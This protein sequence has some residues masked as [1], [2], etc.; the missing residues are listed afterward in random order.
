MLSFFLK[1][2][3][4]EQRL[5]LACREDA[6]IDYSVEELISELKDNSWKVMHIF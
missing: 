5:S 4:F 1:D 6:E 3:D 2:V